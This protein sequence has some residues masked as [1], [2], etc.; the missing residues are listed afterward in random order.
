MAV[1]LNCNAINGRPAARVGDSVDCPKHGTVTIVSGSPNTYHDEQPAARVGDKTS[2]GATIIEGS[3]TVYI[4]GKP[5]AF[6]D[7][8]TT[9]DGK[10]T[11]GSP[12]VYIG[13][14]FLGSQHDNRLEPFSMSV[15]LNMMHEA[16][17]HNGI[18]YDHIAVKITKPDG[19]YLTTTSTDE[20]GITH[21]FYTNEQEEVI[22]WA[23]FGHWEVSEEF[24][25]ID[26]DD[27]EDTE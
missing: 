10:I 27:G 11:S 13:K 8:S 7:C 5:A 21:R 24:E 19:T 2:C 25:D 3:N 6:V 23:D 12:T 1:Y 18:S 20:H 17:N 16:G 26:Y 14:N 15:D 22:A 9:H 4:N